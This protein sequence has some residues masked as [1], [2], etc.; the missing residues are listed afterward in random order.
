MM[1]VKNN[2][3]GDQKA[4]FEIK[5]WIGLVVLGVG[6]VAMF[7]RMQTSQTHS[8]NILVELK[9]EISDLEEEVR[10]NHEEIIRLGGF[11]VPTGEG[12]S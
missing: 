11:S 6:I 3:R 5:E 9:C 1:V 7:V 2:G 10:N 4:T 8:Q 12:N